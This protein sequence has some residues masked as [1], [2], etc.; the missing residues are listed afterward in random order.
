MYIKVCTSSY[1]NITSFCPLKSCIMSR[2]KFCLTKVSI[3]IKIHE[4]QTNKYSVE[5]NLFDI[6]N[7]LRFKDP[8]EQ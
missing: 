1:L 8:M 3:F 4:E 5:T 6:Y 7:H 2:R